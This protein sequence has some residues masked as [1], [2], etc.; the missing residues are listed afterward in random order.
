MGIFIFSAFFFSKHTAAQKE[1]SLKLMK[2]EI[3]TRLR[4][5]FL[6]A[7]EKIPPTERKSKT[8]SN[9]SVVFACLATASR[10]G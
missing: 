9:V 8:S 2:E 1:I 6:P 4:N 7:K 3:K 5:S 10:Q